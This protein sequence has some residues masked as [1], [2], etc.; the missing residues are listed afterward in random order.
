LCA[1]GPEAPPRPTADAALRAEVLSSTQRV[2]IAKVDRSKVPATDNDDTYAA[3]NTA[4]SALESTAHRMDEAVYD[5]TTVSFNP[6]NPP[7]DDEDE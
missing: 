7:S 5:I 2:S 1:P 6:Q 3:L 4:M